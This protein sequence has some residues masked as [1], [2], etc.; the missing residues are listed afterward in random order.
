VSD[1]TKTY[2]K[3]SVRICTNVE[4]LLFFLNGNHPSFPGTRGDVS[5]MTGLADAR[6]NNCKDQAA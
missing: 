1:P 4:F 5:G 2:E 6:F 3:K